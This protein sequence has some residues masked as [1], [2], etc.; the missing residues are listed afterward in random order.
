M[1]PLLEGNTNTGITMLSYITSLTPPKNAIKFIYS[2][3]EPTTEYDGIQYIQTDADLNRIC[4]KRFTEDKSYIAMPVS[5]CDKVGYVIPKARGLSMSLLGWAVISEYD[6]KKTLKQKNQ[7]KLNNTDHAH[8]QSLLF[9]V[10]I[11]TY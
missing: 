4:L 7:R 5:R 2:D 8:I 11:N 3:C 9:D 6:A 1:P 10:L